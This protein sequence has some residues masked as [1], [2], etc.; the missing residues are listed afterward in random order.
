MQAAPFTRGV[1][2]HFRFLNK[3]RV[4]R[5]AAAG[6][7]QQCS[8]L[9]TQCR[10]ANLSSH[11]KQILHS[12]RRSPWLLPRRSF[13]PNPGRP[14]WLHKSPGAARVDSWL[15]RSGAW[16]ICGKEEP[17]SAALNRSATCPY[18]VADSR[19][20]LLVLA[21]LEQYWHDRLTFPT[22]RFDPAWV[23]AA[24]AQHA[25]MATG[26]PAGQHLKLNL[27][28]PNALSTDQFYRTRSA[29]GA[30]DRLLWLF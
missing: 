30:N 29:T 11:E 16:N 28:N 8:R 6:S 12:L 27:A 24:A 23:R 22:G 3:A 25:R 14:A 21:Q 1:G 10:S 19:A 17:C 18:P 7:S 9:L 15:I 20:K 26:V 2:L 4:V 13:N 5:R